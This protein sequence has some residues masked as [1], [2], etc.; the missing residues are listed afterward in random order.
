M[1]QY[2]MVRLLTNKYLNEGVKYGDL[3]YAIEIYDGGHIEVEFSDSSTGI[4]IAQIVVNPEEI[5]Q[6]G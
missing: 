3:G 4:T 6:I 2:A 1:K 5:E